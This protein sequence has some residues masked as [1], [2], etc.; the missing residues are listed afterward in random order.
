VVRGPAWSSP[1]NLSQRDNYCGPENDT[2]GSQQ[3]FKWC[4]L[5]V[6]Q[7]EAL[8]HIGPKGRCQVSG[9]SDLRVE[10]IESRD[11]HPA[12]FRVLVLS[13][14]VAVFD[15]TGSPTFQRQDGRVQL[16]GLVDVPLLIDLLLQSGVEVDRRGG[17]PG[18]CESAPA[19]Q[20]GRGYHRSLNEDAGE[21]FRRAYVW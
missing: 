15:P 5:P 18:D 20:C 7:R 19:D 21:P 9:L 16:L 3:G 1:G 12:P 6:L 4:P 2:G 8:T 13:N 10:R 11:R 17:R 14:E